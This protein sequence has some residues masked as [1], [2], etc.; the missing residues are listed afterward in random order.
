MLRTLDK[1][2]SAYGAAIF[3]AIL[4]GSLGIFVRKISADITVIAIA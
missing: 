2:F 4:M 3:A 1:S